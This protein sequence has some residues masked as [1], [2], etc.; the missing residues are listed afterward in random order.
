[1]SN[2]KKDI[3]DYLKFYIGAKVVSSEG[4]MTYT[5]CGIYHK[6]DGTILPLFRDEVSNEIDLQGDWKLCLRRLESM[7]EEEARE[8]FY[9]VYHF[10]DNNFGLMGFNYNISG[11]FLTFQSKDFNDHPQSHTMIKGWKENGEL[12]FNSS[13]SMNDVLWFL[14]KGFDLFGLID[15]GL[16]IDQATLTQK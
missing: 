1:M 15:S 7:T 8:L 11:M 5:L 6:H 12:V 3:R 2:E 9:E 16:A 13:Y 14:K 10:T 4:A